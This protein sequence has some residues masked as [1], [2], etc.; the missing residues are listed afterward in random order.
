MIVIGHRGAAAL[1]PENTLAGYRFAVELG[2]DM[3]EGDVRMSRDGRA[4]IM[5]DSTVDRTTNGRGAVADQ[6]FDELRRL[7][8]GDGERIPSLDEY[9]DLVRETGIRALVE[10]KSRGALEACIDGILGRGLQE[11]AVLTGRREWMAE[12]KS[13]HPGI[14]VGVPGMGFAVEELDEIRALG[15]EGVGI[16]TSR[17][18]T[19]IVAACH[20]RGLTVRGWNPVTRESILET[21]QFGV[22]GVTT[23]RPDIALD[24]LGRLR[25]A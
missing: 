14:A 23:D 9:L 20:D 8:A 16:H 25:T 11:Q 6:T 5:H 10:V 24:A 2:V 22:D 7:D 13:K 4:V 12:A 19:E 15:A 3:I 21:I 1:K 18:S 17:L